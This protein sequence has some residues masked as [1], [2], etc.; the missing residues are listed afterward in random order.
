MNIKIVKNLCKI[1]RMKVFKKELTIKKSLF[2]AET[3]YGALYK[4][5]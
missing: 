3:T 2:I 5:S 4:N 1:T